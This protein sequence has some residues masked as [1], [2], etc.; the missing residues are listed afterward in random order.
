MRTVGGAMLRGVNSAVTSFASSRSPHEAQTVMP[1][2][3]S[4]PQCGHTWEALDMLASVY[5]Q[6]AGSW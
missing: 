4:M 3:T 5:A 2:V 1:P 6:P